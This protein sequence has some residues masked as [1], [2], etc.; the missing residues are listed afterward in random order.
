MCV[1]WTG[2]TKSTFYS[3]ENPT[4]NKN[5]T[6]NETPL[7]PLLDSETRHNSVHTGWISFKKPPKRRSV[8]ART[9]SRILCTLKPGFHHSPTFMGVSPYWRNFP[10]GVL[11]F[12]NLERVKYIAVQISEGSGLF[13][14]TIYKLTKFS[15]GDRKIQKF[16]RGKMYFCSK[17]RGAWIIF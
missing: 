12:G 10:K 14:Y 6:S 5:P 2:W 1:R 15:E 9:I 16:L 8:I 13:Y 11:K 4:S 17:F 7:G 3:N